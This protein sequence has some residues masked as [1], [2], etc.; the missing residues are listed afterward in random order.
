MSSPKTQTWDPQQ[1]ATN[2][3]FVSDLGMPV[4]QL[5]APQAGERILDLGCGDGALSIK[6]A[7]SG[8]TVVCVDSSPEMVKAAA[9]RGLDGRVADGRSLQFTREFDAVFSNAALH[10]MKDPERVIDGVWHALRP[11]GRF[12]GEFGGHGNVDKIVAALDSGLSSRGKAVA[13]PWFFPQPEQYRKLLET[14]GFQAQT[15]E[16]IPRPTPLPGDVGA[17]LETFAHAYTSVV[18]VDQR[19][20]FIAEVVESLRGDLCDEAGNWT[21]DYV[22]LRFSATRRASS[23][24]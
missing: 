7:E 13:C 1:Y 12:V 24:P 20:E 4:L 19:W 2:A 10:W 9:S 15:I 21:A 22:R 8:C 17:W 23:M 11:G 6:L 3:R 16:L 18:P 5:L 14:A